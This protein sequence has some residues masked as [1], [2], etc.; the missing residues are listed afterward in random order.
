MS[1]A[2]DTFSAL[3]LCVA[4]L[5]VLCWVAGNCRSRG[6]SA[7]PLKINMFSKE[8]C[9]LNDYALFPLDTSGEKSVMMQSI[10]LMKALE[11]C[12]RDLVA[13]VTVRG[14]SLCHGF[15]MLTGDAKT[16]RALVETIDW[17]GDDVYFEEAQLPETIARGQQ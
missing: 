8:R 6:G 1:Y 7:T 11:N 12:P 4:V 15:F 13:S 9:R 17:Q 5:C 3:L 16:L 14:V 10:E 2:E